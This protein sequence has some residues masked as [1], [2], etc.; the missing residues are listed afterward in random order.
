[1]NDSNPATQAGVLFAGRSAATIAEVIA[2]LIIVRLLGKADVGILTALLLVYTTLS[3]VLTAGLPGTLSF[4]LPLRPSEERRAV[5]SSMLRLL[6]YLAGVAAFAQ[7][8]LA[9]MDY[10]GYFQPDLKLIYLAALIGLPFG[11]IPMRMLPN[12]LVIEGRDRSAAAL[13]VIRTLGLTLGT[14]IPLA[15]GL[16]VWAVMEVLSFVGIGFL[17]ITVIYYRRVYGGE[18]VVASPLSAMELMKFS[19]PVGLTEL[20]SN[21]NA[22]FD[23]F[24]IIPLG[25]IAY[26]EYG[27]GSWQIP[28]IPG[29][30][31]A[32]GVAYA[33]RFAELFKSGSPGKAVEIW[34]AQA[35]KT[36][37]IVVPIAIFFAIAAEETIELL[38]TSDYLNG[39]SV[40]RL[41]S[42]MTIGRITAFGSILIAAGRPDYVFRSALIAFGSNVVISV[43]LVLL[44]GFN[45]PALGTLLAFV[46]MVIGYTWYIGRATGVPF[47]QVFPL[48]DLA[49]TV[50]IA[51][52]PAAAA[53]AF[54]IY[55]D[56][57]VIT[58]LAAEAVIMLGGF[59]LLGTVSRLIGREE[60]KF[61]KDFVSMKPFRRRIV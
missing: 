49:K 9:W 52:I 5:A 25:V 51:V 55:V 27:A 56:A 23:R 39:A 28:L 14:L 8:I 53:I 20:V 54:K 21:L 18:P 30:T 12:M 2:P 36:A 61:V 59:G 45:G 43:P 17:V 40:F 10:A 31:Y 11:D 38:F 57:P 13:P 15:L 42:L 46:P 22:R 16:D 7:L 34:R 35:V 4:H 47:A 48:L 26:A 1:M 32:V 29:I 44:I 58:K 50:G 6:L 24:L 19:I 3:M 60:W 41:Y 37:L 33:P